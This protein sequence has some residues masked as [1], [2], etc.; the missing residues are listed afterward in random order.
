MRSRGD[1]IVTIVA[2]PVLTAVSERA[3]LSRTLS[4]EIIYG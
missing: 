2:G 4:T 1:E 3:K